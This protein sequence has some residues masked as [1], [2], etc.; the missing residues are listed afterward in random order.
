MI[1]NCWNNQSNYRSRL[2][3][4]SGTEKTAKAAVV[5]NC[6]RIRHVV[7]AV[8]R[9]R[10]TMN[11][12]GHANASP[13][14]QRRG[15]IRRR[16]AVRARPAVGPER[17][18]GIVRYPCARA[19]RS[20][21][22]AIAERPPANDSKNERCHA[23]KTDQKQARCGGNCHFVTRRRSGN[24]RWLRKRPFGAA[25]RRRPVS[26]RRT[27]GVA[28]NLRWYVGQ[29]HSK[30]QHANRRHPAQKKRQNT[31]HSLHIAPRRS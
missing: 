1:Q 5:V 2:V 14:D 6:K 16:V 8:I 22:S 13:A 19:T 10:H 25:L 27:Q 23:Q 30:H 11:A 26:E 24:C 15:T 21:T 7:L 18:S 17:A 3:P 12:A 9:G 31:R 28:W 29:S 20:F 4:P